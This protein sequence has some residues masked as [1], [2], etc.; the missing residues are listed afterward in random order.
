MC[1][2]NVNITRIIFFIL[3]MKILE[4][5]QTAEK[6]V[7]KGGNKSLALKAIPHQMKMTI[8]KRNILLTVNAWIACACQKLRS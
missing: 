4:S 8:K 5:Q 6:K 3:I 7:E 2:G 1:N